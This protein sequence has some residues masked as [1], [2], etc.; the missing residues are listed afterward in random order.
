M[1][2]WVT[3]RPVP[4]QWTKRPTGADATASAAQSQGK[5]TPRGK[6]PWAQV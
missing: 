4:G 6:F 3:A 5:K 1:N 2:F